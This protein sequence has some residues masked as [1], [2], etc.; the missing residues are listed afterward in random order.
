MPSTSSQCCMIGPDTPS[1]KR[2]VDVA[3]KRLDRR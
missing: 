1:G 2:Q 3:I